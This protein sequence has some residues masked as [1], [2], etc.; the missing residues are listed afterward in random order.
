MEVVVCEAR[1]KIAVLVKSLKKDQSI[2]ESLDDTFTL[3]LSKIKETRNKALRWHMNSRL[4]M[5]S[6]CLHM[7][8]LEDLEHVTN[9]SRVVKGELIKLTDSHA[10]AKASYLKDIRTI[11]YPLILNDNSCT[12]NPCC[13]ENISC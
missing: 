5:M 10:Q 3:D 1:N 12:T 7:L 9:G 11:P 8:L 2:K 13:D 4:R 6:V